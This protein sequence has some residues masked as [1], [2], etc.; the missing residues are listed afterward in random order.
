M[1]EGGLFLGYLGP[2]PEVC[3]SFPDNCLVI[4]WCLLFLV[5]MLLL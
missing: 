3:S 1:S 2:F 4:P 5:A